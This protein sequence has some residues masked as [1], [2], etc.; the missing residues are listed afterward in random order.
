MEKAQAEK[1]FENDRQTVE[2]L[3]L[4]KRGVS[5]V[6]IYPACFLVLFF[7]LPHTW[8]HEWFLDSLVAVMVICSGFRALLIWPARRWVETAPRRWKMAWTAALIT[9]AAAWGVLFA[10]SWRASGDVRTLSGICVAG[11]CMAGMMNNIPSWPL[12]VT[13]ELAVLGPSI[14]VA[15]MTPNR[16]DLAL[17]V[18]VTLFLAFLLFH[19]RMMNRQFWQSHDLR[20]SLLQRTRNLE[21]SSR[22]AEKQQNMIQV[23]QNAGNLALWD[24]DLVTG[25]AECSEQWFNF[26][27]MTHGRNPIRLDDW[28][29]KIHPDDRDTASVRVRETL[30]NDAPYSYDYRV[31]M[32]DGSIRWVNSHGRIFR[33]AGGK[34]LRM[35]GAS[36]DIHARV[37][38]ETAL[39]E[40]TQVLRENVG[41]LDCQT[42]MLKQTVE[43]LKIAKSQA[44]EALLAKSKFLAHMSHEIRTPMNG[45][46]GIADILMT[47][48]LTA[49]Q[50]DYAETIR[51]SG[52]ALLCVINDIL[53]FSKIEAG[54]LEVEQISFS[55]CEVA[56]QCIELLSEGA[57][58][59]ELVLRLDVGP[60]VPVLIFGDPARLRQVLLNL[61]G[62]AIKFTREGSVAVRVFTCNQTE[63]RCRFQ[64]DV[65][66]TGIGMTEEAQ[67][68]MFRAFAQ[69]DSTM[70]RKFGGTGLG[71]VISRGLVELMGGTLSLVSRAGAGSTFTVAI[72]CGIPSDQG[73]GGV[74]SLEFYG[75]HVLA[76]ETCG[77]DRKTIQQ[78]LRKMGML[79]EWAGDRPQL[80]A[81]V[82]AKTNF[83]DAILIG[84]N[85]VDAAEIDFATALTKT[86]RRTP[87]GLIASRRSPGD[88]NLVQEA[89]LAMLLRK[90]LRPTALAVGMKS[91]LRH[92]RMDA[93]Q[94]PAAA[95]VAAS[96]VPVAP[97]QMFR[98]KVLVAEDNA[99]N[100]KVAL[101]LL[102]RLNYD[103]DVV[104]DGLAALEAVLARS[105][106]MV[107]M[108]ANMPVMDGLASTREIRKALGSRKLPIIALTASALAS[109][110]DSCFDAGMDDYLS[111]P[112]Q[113]AELQRVLERWRLAAVQ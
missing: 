45:V 75:R 19:G 40:Q 70:T 46:I 102:Q 89:G 105:Y 9:S 24:W 27:G 14:G 5:V 90:P 69:A 53:D 16:V 42:A 83:F 96:P 55:L 84:V 21:E 39:R 113:L 26:H 33:D 37:V 101:G 11:V 30:K 35:Y 31:I 109:D 78:S 41:Q 8:V 32:D 56:E 15:L 17:A 51:T 10:V 57:A 71:L 108:D 65:Q 100:R 60:E 18:L 74:C 92:G 94:A 22:L 62:N 54:K 44:E 104:N 111:K 59:K 72:D 81:L 110:R 48:R 50:M 12:I 28:L 43:E 29:V 61:I 34:P 64:I 36:V 88:Q 3:G 76:L 73:A 23:A 63:G 77:D 82:E 106:D 87:V 4:L 93:E 6:W 49:E 107:L 112:V 97:R 38:I 25:M 99:V 67:A 1:S 58:K 91:M 98:G 85:A 7:V 103:A 80:R 86:V 68:R 20:L 66:D 2:L 52:E 13:F 79:V 95:V 47:T